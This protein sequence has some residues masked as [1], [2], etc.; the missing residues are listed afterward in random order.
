VLHAL[1]LAPEFQARLREELQSVQLPTGIDEEPLD[2][3]T[4]DA[5]NAL[6][7]LDATLREVLRLWAPV[8]MIVRTA[9]VDD[10]VSLDTPVL[11]RN[12][13]LVDS[14]RLVKILECP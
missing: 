10:V 11:N 3:D 14:F 8:P 2:K 12:G 1:S 7:L 4:L 9:M 6:P 5:L 13:E